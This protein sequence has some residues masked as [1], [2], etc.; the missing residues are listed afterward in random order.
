MALSGEDFVDASRLEFTLI[1]L[2]DLL[3]EDGDAPPRRYPPYRETDNS[4]Q[5]SGES[6]TSVGAQL[7][8]ERKA[9]IGQVREMFPDLGEGFVDAALESLSLEG[10]INALNLL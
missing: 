6:G 5:N 8:S 9:E 2:S 4:P 3:P 7:S 10:L 1:A